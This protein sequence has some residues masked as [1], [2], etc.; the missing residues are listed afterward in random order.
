MGDITQNFSRHEFSLPADKAKEYGFEETP[1]P[2]EW[3]TE[4]LEPLCKALERIRDACGGRKIT[5]ISGYRPPG[6]DLAR[7]AAGHT[8]VSEHS[9]HG[10]GRAADIR[11]AGVTARQVFNAALRLATTSQIQIG[12]LGLYV[13]EDFVHVDVRPLRRGERLKTW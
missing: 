5:V 11:V 6:Y 13:E 8:G 9:Q 12:G 1:Y 2:D 3:V 7:R 4:R 10:E